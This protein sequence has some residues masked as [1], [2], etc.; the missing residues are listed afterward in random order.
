MNAGPIMLR[1]SLL[2][3]RFFISLEMIAIPITVGSITNH[4]VPKR[5]WIG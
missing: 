2:F 3:S 5:N 4:V 1:N